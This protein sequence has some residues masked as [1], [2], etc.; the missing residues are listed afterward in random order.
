MYSRKKS[1]SAYP[2]LG[3]IGLLQLIFTCSKPRTEILKRCIKSVHSWHQR[4]QKDVIEVIL[5]S[6]LLNFEQMLHIVLCFQWW[7]WTY[8]CQLGPI[9]WCAELHLVAN[10]MFKVNYRNTRT[11][12][13]IWS[14]LTIK[15]PERHHWRRSGIFIVNFEHISHLFLVFLIVNFK[16]VNAGW[17]KLTV[18]LVTLITQ[19]WQNSNFWDW[20]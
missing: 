11:R 17:D 10:Y 12:C 14:K 18:S 6:L 15:T 3:I 19:K 4:H 20:N 5:V 1:L 7:L 13:E 2:V 16:Q 9:N 8:T